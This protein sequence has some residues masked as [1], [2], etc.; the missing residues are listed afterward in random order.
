[1]T[2]KLSLEPPLGTIRTK[3]PYRIQESVPGKLKVRM[4]E[5]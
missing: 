2:S 3:D 1:M 4:A 5:E